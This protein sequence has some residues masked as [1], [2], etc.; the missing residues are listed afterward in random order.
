MTHNKEIFQ[1]DIMIK[2]GI[3]FV[4]A[5]SLIVCI[6]PVSVKADD[7]ALFATAVPP[8]LLIILDLTGSMADNPAGD[9]PSQTNETTCLNTPSNNCSKLN[10][11]KQAIF[12]I[13]DYNGDGK[14]DSSDMTGLNIRIGYMRYTGS[15]CQEISGSNGSGG[16]WSYSS[17]C[18]Q[19]I[20]GIDNGV[21]NGT[22][23]AKIYCNAS[24]ASGSCASV[25]A[26]GSGNSVRNSTANGGTPLS[27]SLAEAR[28]YMDYNKSQD[29]LASTC[30][31]KFVLIVTD[32]ED[33][34][35]CNG[36]GSESQSNMNRR[37]AAVVTYAKALADADYKVFVIGFGSNQSTALKNTLNWAAYYGKTDNPNI[38]DSWKTGDPGG[39][40][41]PAVG[42]ECSTSDD[43]G[44]VSLS[45]YAF[46][47]TSTADLKTGLQSVINKIK[48]GAYAFSQPYIASSR[49]N[50]ENYIYQASFEPQVLP[51]D[52]MWVGHLK[53]YTILTGG[54]ISPTGIVDAGS[55]LQSQS[56]S[57]RVIK[58]YVG[59]LINFTN[60]ITP[61]TFALATGDTSTRDKIVTFIRGGDTSPVNKLGDIFD[62]NLA[63]LGTPTTLFT[64]IIDTGNNPTA[65]AQFRSAHQ[66]TTPDNTRIIIGGAND[67]QLHAF[68]TNTLEEAWS[69]IPPN[70][71]PNLK[72]MAH[73]THPTVLLH[74]YMVDGPVTTTEAWLCSGSCTQTNKSVSDWHSLIIF[75]LGKGSSNQLW[76]SMAKCD[77]S[78]NFSATYHSANYPYYCGYYA[79][80]ATTSPHTTIDS[81]K[82]T[83]GTNAAPG[84]TAAPYLGQPWSK[85]STGRVKIGGVEKWVGFVGGGYNAT[86]CTGGACD[87]RGKGLFVIDLA[88]G[89]VI[90]AFTKAD[91]TD[92]KYSFPAT[93]T[94]ADIDADGFIDTA[95]IGDMGG[96]MWRLK[97]CKK[98]DG[99]SCVTGSWIL[100]R[101][102]DASGETAVRPIYTKPVLS[103]DMYGYVWVYWGTG[104]TQNPTDNAKGG[105]FY[106]LKD[107]GGTYSYS[108]LQGL[109]GSTVYAGLKQGWRIPLTGTGEKVLGDA[110]LYN[111]VVYFTSFTPAGTDLCSQSGVAKLYEAQY[112]G[113]DAYSGSAYTS[114]TLAG[115]GIPSAPVVSIGP[116]GSPN[117]YVTVS[118]AG[119]TDAVI[120]NP[121][122]PPGSGNAPKIR[123]WRD[124]RVQ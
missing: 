116:G 66:R 85:M 44:S 86:D 55:V 112:T 101:L 42:S 19:I 106:A 1:E 105:Q 107:G 29:T 25:T 98:T 21:S 104:D 77:G 124:K 51:N 43:P 100:S 33:T 62:S 72:S 115:V 48:E 53:R 81:L 90:R 99:T 121:K 24:G 122:N 82:W 69:F 59:G 27:A 58:T 10:I 96:N 84:S 71:L 67:G 91:Y 70:T 68:K 23:Y 8:D 40:T 9:S 93:F 11:A 110:D 103:K 94:K 114:T 76:S 111:G 120:L 108:D 17:G 118:G 49:T 39:Y 16:T 26:S 119:S 6:C 117:L 30:R 36:N 4:L 35:A 37:R 79:L 3:A 80:E 60:T 102:Y 7:T 56:A 78:S 52:P 74:S 15:S 65:F 73:D 75:G 2:Y 87:T 88:D 123:Y 61:T 83:I 109:S 22:T 89:S 31:Q 54:A 92:M 45:G 97:L 57:S 28:M 34:Y 47:A 18:N 14:I 32:G 95:Y 64:D 50:D 13:L 113:G 46:I 38:V 41:P 63:I 5:L 12:N 20:N